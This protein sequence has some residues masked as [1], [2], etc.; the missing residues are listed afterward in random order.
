M[1]V[2]LVVG[3]CVA[4]ANAQVSDNAQMVAEKQVIEQNK[5]PVEGLL[6]PSDV[7]PDTHEYADEE[8]IAL[9]EDAVFVG[10]DVESLTHPTI[11]SKVPSSHIGRG[12][13]EG[14]D[15]LCNYLHNATLGVEEDVDVHGPR[16][17]NLAA[18]LECE[19]TACRL[20]QQRMFHVFDYC[21]NF[22]RTDHLLKGLCDDRNSDVQAL[23]LKKMVFHDNA[24]SCR[25][26][27]ELQVLDMRC[28]PDDA[29]YCQGAHTVA[30]MCHAL[31]LNEKSFLQGKSFDTLAGWFCHSKALVCSANKFQYPMKGVDVVTPS[32]GDEKGALGNGLM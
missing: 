27:K 5:I 7:H 8:K 3:L 24:E 6:K 22:G 18:R 14:R 31:G 11:T 1:K 32:I 9:D 17:Y 21:R 23:R 20:C 15:E 19:W 26:W 16:L 10:R 12:A 30:E 25:S 4:L 13:I 2:L 28:S 29:A